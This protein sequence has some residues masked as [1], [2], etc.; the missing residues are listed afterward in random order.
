MPASC[1]AVVSVY[2]SLWPVYQL[3]SAMESQDFFA[4]VPGH[5]ELDVSG[6]GDRKGAVGI[7]VRV[8]RGDRVAAGVFQIQILRGDV[9]PRKGRYLQ[10]VFLQQHVAAVYRLA[11]N[12][13][14]VVSDQL[15]ARSL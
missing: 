9:L 7:L 6:A 5:G 3:V 10:D 2:V 14:H 15:K 11:G 1:A 12:I 4:C 8:R 13:Y